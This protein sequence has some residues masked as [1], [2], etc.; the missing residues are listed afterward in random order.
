[1]GANPSSQCII[2]YMS[3]RTY[4]SMFG[5]C[6]CGHLAHI[7]IC[8]GSWERWIEREVRYYHI[9]LFNGKD[10]EKFV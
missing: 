1:M 4:K 6:L 9:G 2:Y 8:S 10:V 3:A 7:C 5:S